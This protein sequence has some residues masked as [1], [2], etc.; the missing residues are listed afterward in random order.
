MSNF[1][2]FNEFRKTYFQIV[3]FVFSNISVL[4]FTT[5]HTH[6]SWQE[7]GSKM[8]VTLIIWTIEGL[9]IRKPVLD[10]HI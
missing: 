9:N 3:N 10:V 2:D 5:F 7:N 1:S 8:M 6:T 4:S